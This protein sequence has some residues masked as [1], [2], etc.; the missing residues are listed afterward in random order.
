MK[1]IEKIIDNILDLIDTAVM[2]IGLLLIILACTAFL[3][4][5]WLL[6]ILK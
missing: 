1:L 5:P 2:F 6:F 4:L 3:W